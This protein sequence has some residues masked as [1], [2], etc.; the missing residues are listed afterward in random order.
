MEQSL[1]SD[2]LGAWKE[3]LHLLREGFRRAPTCP[4]PFLNGQSLKV[5]AHHNPQLSPSSLG[6]NLYLLP[7]ISPA[8]WVARQALP[9]G[10]CAEAQP[11]PHC[12]A[13]QPAEMSIP[14]IHDGNNEEGPVPVSTDSWAEGQEFQAPVW[15]PEPCKSDLGRG[16]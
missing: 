6:P 15:V 14:A 16:C 9:D 10:L 1:A 5:V 11:R 7:V 8:T 3:Q 12:H 2:F 4:S 13:Q